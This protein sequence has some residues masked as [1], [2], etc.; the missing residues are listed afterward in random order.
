MPITIGV[1]GKEK[2][3]MSKAFT[4]NYVLFPVEYD[5][6][7]WVGFVPRNPKNKNEKWVEPTGH[8]GG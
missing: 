5:G 7:E 6:S 4:E 1:D 2:N 3:E 8:Y